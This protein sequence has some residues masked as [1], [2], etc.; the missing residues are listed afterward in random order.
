MSEIHREAKLWKKCNKNLLKFQKGK[1]LKQHKIN[2]RVFSFSLRMKKNYGSNIISLLNK[3]D[4]ELWYSMTL[5]TSL[6][7]LGPQ[8]LLGGL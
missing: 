1:I 6:L 8:G 2:A 3:M 5:P 4:N 7:F